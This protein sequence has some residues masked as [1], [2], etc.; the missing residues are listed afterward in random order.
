MNKPFIKNLMLG[1]SIKELVDYVLDCDQYEIAG[2]YGDYFD[3]QHKTYRSYDSHDWW[4]ELVKLLVSSKDKNI[5]FIEDTPDLEYPNDA[6]IFAPKLN[7]SALRYD[8]DNYHYV[9][10]DVETINNFIKD[11]YGE[12]SKPVSAKITNKEYA[13]KKKCPVCKKQKG[14]RQRGH[15]W[16]DGS[17]AHRNLGCDLCNALWQENFVISTFSNLDTR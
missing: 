13:S 16:V 15:V 8:S 5:R 6:E 10:D 3:E 1:T 2:N 14:I 7:L 9:E 12:K 11:F 17:Q 4:A